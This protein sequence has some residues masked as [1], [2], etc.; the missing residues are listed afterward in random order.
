MRIPDPWIVTFSLTTHRLN[1]IHSLSLFTICYIINTASVPKGVR[2]YTK[3]IAGVRSHTCISR[4]HAAAGAFFMPADI[5]FAFWCIWKPLP[6]G[7]RPNLRHIFIRIKETQR[8]AWM[9]SGQEQWNGIPQY[10]WKDWIFKHALSIMHIC[11]KDVCRSK[12]PS[13]VKGEFYIELSQ[14]HI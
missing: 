13:H 2:W 6:A 11:K 1:N 4:E 12:H 9:G 14:A 10:R 7:C 5:P 3:C 8:A